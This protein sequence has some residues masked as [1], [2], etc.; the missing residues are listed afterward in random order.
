[1]RIKGETPLREG[2]IVRVATEIDRPGGAP[3]L[4]DYLFRDTDAGWKVFDVIVEGISYVQTY[5]TQF[6]ELLRRKSLAQVTAELRDGTID[7]EG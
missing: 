3:V 7:V 6:A 1:M 5:R 4:I 2:A